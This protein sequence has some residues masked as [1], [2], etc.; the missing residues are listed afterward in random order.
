MRA[1]RF[2]MLELSPGELALAQ[3][4]LGW[5]GT[6]LTDA[7]ELAAALAA[8]GTRLRAEG[9]AGEL[10]GAFLADLV[11]EAREAYGADASKPRST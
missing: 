10:V 5:R 8:N 4:F 6:A 11:R 7:D 2:G 3:Q 9:D 1:A